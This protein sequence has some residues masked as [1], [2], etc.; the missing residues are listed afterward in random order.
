M[1]TED[2]ALP[3]ARPE[4][5]VLESQLAVTLFKKPVAFNED[6]PATRLFVALAAGDGEKHLNAL[7]SLMELFQDEER[8]KAMLEAED[9]ESLFRYF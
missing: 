6:H 1:L 5:G 2:I 8:V 7:A 9:R 3:H 4:Q